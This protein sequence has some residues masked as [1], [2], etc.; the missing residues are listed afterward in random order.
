MAGEI[1]VQNGVLKY[2]SIRSGPYQPR[3]NHLNQG[4]DYLKEKGLSFDSAKVW[5][6]FLGG[7]AHYQNFYGRL[8]RHNSSN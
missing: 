5:D 1:E 2:F 3:T 6:E 7:W 8:E 4:K